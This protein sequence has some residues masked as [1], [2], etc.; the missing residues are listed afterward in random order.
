MEKE[1]SS[2]IWPILYFKADWPAESYKFD[3]DIH[4]IKANDDILA[5]LKKPESF[6][7][8]EAI[9][10]FSCYTEWFLALPSPKPTEHVSPSKSGISFEDQ[11]QQAIVDSFLLCLKLIRQTAAI[12]PLEVRNVEFEGASIDPDS[13]ENA[14]DDYFGINTDNPPVFMPESF[15]LEDLQLLTELWSAII[16]LRN[17]DCW[18]TWIY[19]EVFWA[20]CDKKAGQ[21]AVKKIVD[22]IMSSPAYLELSEEELKQH[23]KHW[24]ASFNEA[25]YKG[26]QFLHDLYKD[27]L[28]KVFLQEQEE[29]FSNR[30]RIGRALNLF[31]EGLRL[32]L[33]NSFLSMCLVLETIFTV[34]ETEITYQFATRLANITGETFEQRKDIFERARKVYR[35]RSNIVHGRKSIETVPPNILKDGF[36][37]ARQSLQRILLDPNLLELYSDPITSDKTKNIDKAIEAIKDYFRDLDLR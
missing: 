22:V 13:F 28:E 17:L 8:G 32:P 14:L 36:F 19:E 10:N 7:H 9:H 26:D 4:L 6:D 2:R 33:Q 37:F 29:A 35:E 15:H 11:L 34:E 20:D 5:I 30:T 25:L 23:R 27:N 24:T 3:F 31:F 1:C 12:C 21:D 18:S 16:K